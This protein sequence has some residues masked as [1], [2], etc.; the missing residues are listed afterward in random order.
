MSSVYAKRFEAVFLCTHPKGPLMSYTVAAKYIKK[1]KSFVKK[2]VE[3]YKANKK[4][5]VKVHVWG[6]FSQRGF[7]CLEL[8]TENL[9]A[10]K[11]LQIYERGLLRS[12]TK[13]FGAD[14]ADWIL[15][16]NNDPKHR[17]RLC[18]AWKTENG[19]TTLDWPSQSP[20]ANPIENVWSVLKRK[21]AGKR[22]FTLKQLSQKIRKI[23]QEL[24]TDYAEKLVE[25]MPKRCQAILD[26]DGDWTIY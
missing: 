8:F 3:R 20:D 14:T 11:M 6:C 16:E 18:T 26:N 5:P 13:M 24:P 1:S 2:W 17:S 12:A 22:V 19:I 7:G 10:Q 21:L 25:S 15:Q 9:N 4:H 23:W